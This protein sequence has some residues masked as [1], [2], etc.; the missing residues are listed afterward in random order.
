MIPARFTLA[1]VAVGTLAVSNRVD[2]VP[3]NYNR[4]QRYQVRFQLHGGVGGRAT[5]QP[6]GTGEIG[7]LAGAEQFYVIPYAWN[8]APWWSDDQVE[9][10]S[11][12]VDALKRRYNIDENR[13]AISGVSDG[14]T[15]PNSKSN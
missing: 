11:A 4:A 1:I 14:C 12:I 9:N 3:Q 8:D 15:R 10:L 6:R 2:D 7:T 5:N 13:V